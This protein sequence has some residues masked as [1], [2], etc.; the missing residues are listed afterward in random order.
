MCRSN[1]MDQFH[2]QYCFSNTGSTKQT[3]FS[4]LRIRADQVNNLNTSLKDFCSRHLLFIIRCRTMNRPIFFCFRS[5]KIIYRITQQV[6]YTSQTFLTDRNR[7]RFPCIHSFCAADQTIGGIHSD[8]ANDIIT[9]LLCHFGGQLYAVI[10]NLYRIQKCRQL[11]MSET[12]IQNRTDD[13]H[14]F[15]YMFITHSYESPLNSKLACTIRCLP[16]L[17]QFQ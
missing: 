15:S 8:T 9:Y 1:I 12:D 17:Q 6:K 5:R 13:L 14:H 16:H 11:I 7:N 2:D 3:N 4:T 10:I